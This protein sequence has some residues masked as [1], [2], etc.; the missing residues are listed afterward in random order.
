M[1]KSVNRKDPL[2]EKTF[3]FAI[4]IVKLNQFLI[5]NKKE[6]I[7][8]K[9]ILRSGTNPGAM[10]RE[11]AH[12]ESPLD[13][14]HKLAIARKEIGE[15]AY[16]LELLF[17][18]HFIN[19]KEFNSILNDADEIGRMLTSSIKTKKKNIGIKVSSIE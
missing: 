15:T 2:R 9:Q 4:R 13:F 12:A 18:T 16:W 19:E 8:S 1:R 7:I 17:A 14:I 10:V 6:F 11:A 5:S 3:S